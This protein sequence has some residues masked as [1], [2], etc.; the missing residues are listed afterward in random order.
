MRTPSRS[1][2]EQILTAAEELLE[3]SGPEALTVRGIAEAAGVAPMGVYNHF[4]S[5]E[6]VLGGLVGEGFRRLRHELEEASEDPDPALAL[7][8]AG[9]R[10][11]ALALESPGIYR[12]MFGHD[13]ADRLSDEAL[14]AG[15]DSAFGALVHMV[16]RLQHAHH[17][18]EPPELAAQAIWSQVHGWVSLEL[19]G[20][21]FTEHPD[22]AFERLLEAGA[23]VA[24]PRG[25]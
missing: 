22:I 2:A 7:I 10:Y 1:V 15:A 16:A 11:R 4:E 19:A 17:Y 12:L 14:I 13:L 9:R 8:D 25:R 6:G 18:L 21:V 23:T 20:A 3:Q 5:K 24:L